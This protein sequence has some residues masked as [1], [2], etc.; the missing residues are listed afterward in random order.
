MNNS[1]EETVL[2][3]PFMYNRNIIC[4]IT[5]ALRKQMDQQS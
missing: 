1:N 2:Y 5:N 4:A 3:L